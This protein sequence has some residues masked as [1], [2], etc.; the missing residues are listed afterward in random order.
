MRGSDGRE[1]RAGHHL[2]LNSLRIRVPV[3]YLHP[4]FHAF[5]VI[6]TAYF[7][8]ISWTFRTSCMFKSSLPHQSLNAYITTTSASASDDALDASSVGSATGLCE[9]CANPPAASNA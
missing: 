8:Q 9:W 7:L 3:L 1:R 2:E 6:R 5:Q 4:V